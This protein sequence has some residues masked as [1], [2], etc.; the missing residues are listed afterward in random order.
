[1]NVP[2]A[3]RAFRKYYNAQIQTGMGAPVYFRGSTYMRGHGNFGN[4]MSSLGTFLKPVGQ[5]LAKTGINA[6][7]NIANDAVM[8]KSPRAAAKRRGA[9]AFENVKSNASKKLISTLGLPSPKMRASRSVRPVKKA[10]KNSKTRR[11]K[12]DRFGTY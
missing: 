1:M 8:G 12:S 10:I 7:A 5:S 3:E 6:L 11:K 4:F 2:G 9:E